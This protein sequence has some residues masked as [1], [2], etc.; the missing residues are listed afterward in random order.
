MGL[1]AW[2]SVFTYSKPCRT[3]TAPF[4]TT[5]PDLGHPRQGDHFELLTRRRRVHTSRRQHSRISDASTVKITMWSVLAEK[6]TLSW[7]T[8]AAGGTKV[9]CWYFSCDT[10]PPLEYSPNWNDLVKLSA[11]QRTRRAQRHRDVDFWA[12]S[13]FVRRRIPLDII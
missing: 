9:S 8:A 11:G 7:Q 3:G 6:P 4:K 2:T 1:E 5:N 12:Q 13:G 10:T